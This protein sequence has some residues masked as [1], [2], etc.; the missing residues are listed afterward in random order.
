M[1][2][3]TNKPQPK[4]PSEI[5][6]FLAGTVAICE[7]PARGKCFEE[8]LIFFPILSV[9]SGFGEALDSG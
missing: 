8:F 2:P 5:A 3:D 9:H 4:E 1:E 7:A 6:S